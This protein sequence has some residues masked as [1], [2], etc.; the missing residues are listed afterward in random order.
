MLLGDNEA[1]RLADPRLH[2]PAAALAAGELVDG[3]ALRP[4]QPIDGRTA[5]EAALAEHEQRR[6]TAVTAQLHALPLHRRLR[7]ERAGFDSAYDAEHLYVCTSCAL[8]CNDDPDG[9]GLLAARCACC[10]GSLVP[11]AYAPDLPP[12]LESSLDRIAARRAQL[13]RRR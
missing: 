2:Q 13:R 1:V 6:E 9:R 10:G 3:C 7:T 5:F 11:L 4:S 12:P 8:P